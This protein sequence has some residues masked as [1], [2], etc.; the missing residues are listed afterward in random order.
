MDKPLPRINAINRPFWEGC[1]RGELV[2]QQ[3]DAPGCRRYVYYPRV[4]CPYC[5]NGDL[6]WRPVSGRGHIATF[7]VV[8]RPQH[9]GF[10]GE[11]PYF[12]IAVELQEG[13]LMYSRLAANP[14]TQQGV[15][16]HAVQ[17]VFND[18]MPQQRLP[19]FK[20]A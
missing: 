14:P 1:N 4:C 16:G 2:L 7:T 6:T 8:H 12:V 5:G 11:A 17:V 3:C 13:P 9:K 19:Y 20:L 15:L 10:F 18:Y